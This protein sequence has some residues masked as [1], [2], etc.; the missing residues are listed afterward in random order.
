MIDAAKLAWI[1][2][3][4]QC[5]ACRWGGLVGESAAVTCAACRMSFPVVNGAIDFL[6]DV[7]KAAFQITDTENVSDH[8]FDGNAMAII[9]RCATAGGVVLDCGSGYKA[10]AFPHVVQMEI[11]N[12]AHVD[13]L[14][15]NQRLPFVDDCFDAVF[16]L[17]VLEHVN[18]PFRCAAEICRVYGPADICT[19]TCRSCSL[20][21]AT[22][23]TISTPPVRGFGDFS[24]RWTCCTTMFRRP[25][26]PCR[27]YTT[28]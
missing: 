2:A 22:R 6:D 3:N 9:D 16:S 26:A 27:P 12:Y 15:V 24:R 28:Y 1:A 13:V 11:V 14:A 8:P 5:P 20:S 4:G 17:D 21:T 25:G 10:D 23:S 7:T 19:S 18:D